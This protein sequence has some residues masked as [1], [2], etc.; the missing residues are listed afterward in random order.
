MITGFELHWLQ[1][2]T[3]KIYKSYYLFSVPLGW[4]TVIK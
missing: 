3:S 4:A 2:S 1:G